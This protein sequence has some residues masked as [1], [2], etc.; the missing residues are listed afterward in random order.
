M[1][2]PQPAVWFEV[3]CARDD[4]A[5]A[6]EALGSTGAA[7][8]ERH[9]GV[10]SCE[11][12]SDLRAAL[13]R[14]A[15]LAQKFQAYWPAALPPT[16]LAGLPL[17][18][19]LEGALQGVLDW[20]ASAEAVV[21]ALQVA[22]AEQAELS[23][24]QRVFASLPAA[25]LDLGDLAEAGPVLRAAVL[26]R[27]AGAALALAPG[28][29]SL[30][31]SCDGEAGT[32]ILGAA[33]TVADIAGAPAQPTLR[34]LAVPRW[35]HGDT[36]GCAGEASLRL[37]ALNE[38]TREL[39]AR[40]QALH[41]RHGLPGALGLLW[42]LQW[43]AER[44]GPLE[45]S[46]TLARITGWTSD[47][48]RASAAL[49]G[50]A[51]RA[52]VH[53]PPAPAGASP[54]LLLRNP[55]WARPFELFSQAL[56]MPG[57]NEA[58]PSRLLA[59]LVPLLFGYMFGDLG[60]GLV[61]LVVAGALQRRWAR[62]RMLVA[63]GASAAVF[64]L[65]FGSVFGLEHLLSPL[66]VRPL[67]AP[68]QV[69]AVPLLTGAVLIGLSMLLRGLE[70]WW[71]G[72]FGGWLAG[73][74]LL[75]ALYA[76]AFAGLVSPPMWRVAAGVLLLFLLAGAMRGWRGFLAACG[77]LLEKLP[78]LVIN[79]LSFARL[80]AFALAHAGLS[81]AISALTEAAPGPVAKLLVVLAGNVIVIA[82]EALVVSVQTTRLVL[83]EFF[84]RFMRGEGR[85]FRPLAA[86][87]YLAQGERY[88]HPA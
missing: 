84:I 64:G 24:W 27:P 81:S 63:C 38:Q 74:A 68:L 28:V 70:A 61:L 60:Q 37:A 14:F 25:G 40:L 42:R 76:S 19:S 56:G 35:A 58:D 8:L 36:A 62:A 55:P 48:Q 20:A 12:C 16:T 88:D 32:L 46:E 65:L 72:E 13:E 82:S 86:P 22:A 80:G 23:L 79:T 50:S 26:L 29:L 69:L 52:L 4:A 2:R 54:P 66:W 17:T 7:E 10:A 6:T 78:Q 43:F 33:T 77:E 44:I 45:A 59:F 41:R 5:V 53:F 31:F 73:D 18:Q 34:A 9:P 75:L 87:P 85:L 83:F 49:A 30:E 57:R 1:M 15:G 39:E 71:R 21:R 67:E 51:A 11:L 3:L 47:A